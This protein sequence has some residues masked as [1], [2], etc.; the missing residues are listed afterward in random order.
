MKKLITLIFLAFAF[1]AQAQF[2]IIPQPVEIQQAKG[3]FH[4]TAKTSISYN[5]SDGQAVA[6]ML[7]KKLSV[8]TGFSLETQKGD[9]G[10]I[11]LNLSDSP[12]ESIG[13]EG[14]T[15]AVD[16]QEK[17][18]TITANKPAGLFYGMHTLL[19]LLPPKIESGKAEKS[20][21]AIPAVNI[22]DY[23]RFGWRGLMLDVSRHFFSKEDVMAYID[24]MAKY[25]F[26]VFHWHLTDDNGWRVEIK[27]L[28]K[29]T[30]VGAWR[31]ERYGDFGERA[32]PKPG[33]PATYG[34][35]YSHED[36]REV[37]KYAAERNV[38]IVPEIDVPGHS[39][40]ALAAYPELSC[41]G[42]KVY[43]NPG[44][45]FSQWYGNGTFKMLVE[46]TLNPADEEV[47]VFMEKVITE[48]AELFP[49]E[50]IHIGGDECYKGYWKNNADCQALMKRLGTHHVED[51]QG[52]F[53]ERMEKI[54]EDKGKKMIGWDEIL[55]G[56]IS[57]NA[58]VMS[59]RGMKGGIEAAHLGHEVVMSPTT[60]A[61][62]DYTQGDPTVDPPIYAR[63]RL[64]KTY[65]FEPVPDGV[66]PKYIL[67]GQGNLWTE[68]IPH[69]RYA[70]YM[71]FPR[72]WALSETVWSPKEAKNW[73]DF[74]RRTEVHFDRFDRAEL[75][76]ST[77][78]YDAIVKAK[79]EEDKLVVMMK[80]E[81]PGLDVYYT[82]DDTMPDAFSPKATGPVTLPEGPI[83]LRV[84]TYRDGEPIGHLI[85]LSRKQLE[86]RVGWY[87]LFD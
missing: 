87:D 9:N 61:Y 30:E 44:T 31:V 46:N 26:N 84:V 62:L 79:K 74:V 4:L 28:P 48:V 53:M 47:Y 6:E 10:N 39:M 65:S 5:Q 7:A 32:D 52:Y 25:K 82:I 13:D 67:G 29:L 19:Q 24:L 64:N 80:P 69:L 3:R 22:T 75:N 71:T 40:A 42:E 68:Q 18:L 2:S 60:F 45:P 35:F 14:Y 17:S 57:E 37:V 85:T 21:W 11:R 20:L 83:T 15:L 27:S 55:E 78:I 73:E 51:L 63:L 36:I 81:I 43:V 54:I 12:I 76:Y 77:A 72:A 16:G 66:D 34:G 49:G 1:F 23:P 41:T 50:Y 56:G 86:R 8:P 33:E 59:W 70:Q 38:T 58:A